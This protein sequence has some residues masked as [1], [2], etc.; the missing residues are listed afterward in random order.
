[1]FFHVNCPDCQHEGFASSLPKRL[2]CSCCDK[3]HYFKVAQGRPLI[4][5]EPES[6]TAADRLEQDAA[7]WARAYESTAAPWRA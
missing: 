6:D 5:P 2:R 7:D 3:V 1:M 4:V